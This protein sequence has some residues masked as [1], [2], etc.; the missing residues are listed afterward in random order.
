MRSAPSSPISYH[1]ICAQRNK[2]VA[3]VGF[4]GTKS[5]S[6]NAHLPTHKFVDELMPDTEA[7]V[8]SGFDADR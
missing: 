7:Q 5:L 6:Y 8:L 4:L 2:E 3:G 1:S